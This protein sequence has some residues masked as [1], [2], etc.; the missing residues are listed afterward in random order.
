MDTYN[1]VF[2][3][4]LLAYVVIGSVIVAFVEHHTNG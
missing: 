4:V 3:A 1:L 2:F